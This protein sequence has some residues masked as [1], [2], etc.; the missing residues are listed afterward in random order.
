VVDEHG[1]RL[2]RLRRQVERH[3]AAGRDL[4]DVAYS[5]TPTVERDSASGVTRVSRQTAHR[6]INRN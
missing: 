5:L 4:S 3:E 1:L 2:R 6:Y